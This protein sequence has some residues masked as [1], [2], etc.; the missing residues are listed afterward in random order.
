MNTVLFVAILALLAP[1]AFSSL[2]IHHPSAKHSLVGVVKANPVECEGCTLL[3]GQIENW[4]KDNKS[5]AQIAKDLS[6][7]CSV[8]GKSEKVACNA[9]VIAGVPTILAM[10]ESKNTPTEICASISICGSRLSKHHVSAEPDP[11]QCETCHVI[12]RVVDAWL[13]QNKSKEA[14]E[15]DL[16]TFCT[17]FLH[18]DRA[19]CDTI[20][21]TDT[22][23]LIEW[24]ENNE[25]PE[26]ACG[27]DQLK[28]C[29][30]DKAVH[31]LGRA[32]FHN[33]A[34]VY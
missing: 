1:V 7:L 26:K 23:K 22:E 32:P 6:A 27:Q 13:A 25:T 28:Y 31:P 4:A 29:H 33:S 11:I 16:K 15:R 12:V 20:A 2:P 8:V 18:K 10:L 17:F 34:N 30:D 24:I 21:N 5:E 19:T 3:V 9:L 14:I